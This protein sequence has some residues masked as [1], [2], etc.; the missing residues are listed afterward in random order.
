MSSIDMSRNAMFDSFV[1]QDAT[2]ESLLM[3][4][5]HS[6]LLFVFALVWCVPYAGQMQS[7]LGQIDSEIAFVVDEIDLVPEGICHD[8]RTDRFYFSSKNSDL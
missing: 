7:D 3:R 1:G 4:T 8:A 6:T 5:K 2:K